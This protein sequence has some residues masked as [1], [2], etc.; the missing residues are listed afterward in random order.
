MKYSEYQGL[1]SKTGD[2][3]LSEESTQAVR[4]TPQ[5]LR[6]ETSK[7]AMTLLC[8]SSN[9]PVHWYLSRMLQRIL[10]EGF[11]VHI[12]NPSS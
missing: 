10:R 11:D 3:K 1:F 8:M 7:R 4:M 5:L 6:V 9:E 12:I 2:V